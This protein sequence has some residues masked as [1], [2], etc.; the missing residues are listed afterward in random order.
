M[1]YTSDNQWKQVQYKRLDNSRLIASHFTGHG[2]MNCCKKIKSAN[3][4]LRI[5]SE[6]KAYYDGLLKCHSVWDCPYCSGIIST[7]RRKEIGIALL[8]WAEAKGKVKLITYTVKHNKSDRLKDLQ[9]VINEAYRFSK[10]GSTYQK[11]KKEYKIKGSIVANEINYSDDF[12]W[13]YHRHEIVFY[14]SDQ[15]FK[16]FEDVIYKR[17]YS[18]LSELGFSSLPGIGVNVS[19]REGALSTYLSKW[20]L[21]NEL[22]SI[23]D[24]NSRTPFQL[25]DE[26]ANEDDLG[27][28]L[29]YSKTMKGKRRLTWSNGL[30]DF[31]GIDEISDEDITEEEQNSDDLII[32]TIT[33]KEWDYIL[34]NSLYLKVL[35]VAGSPGIDFYSWWCDN[36]SSLVT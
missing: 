20:G 30:K 35:E 6:G 22:T 4:K 29:E 21:D 14:N 12:G 18:K 2:V 24:S 10:S 27:L 17:Y 19:E 34:Q 25:L 15:D 26:L 7:K 32:T 33:K 31:F 36:V 28:F 16:H 3:L 1:D 13:H 11:L 23:K 5:N 9:N 8:T